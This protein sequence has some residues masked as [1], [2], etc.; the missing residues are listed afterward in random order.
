M[1]HQEMV[2][3]SAD[4]VRVARPLLILV[5]V[6]IFVLGLTLLGG[7]VYLGYFSRLA[8]TD[9]HFWGLALKTTSVGLGMAG[10]GAVMVIRGISRTLKSLEYLAQLPPDDHHHRRAFPSPD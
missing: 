8:N 7:G 3:M 4:H 10:V 1:L 2:C 9:L 5:T 6:V